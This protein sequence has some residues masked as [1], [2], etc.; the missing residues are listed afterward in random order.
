[1]LRGDQKDL[2]ITIAPKHTGQ[3]RQVYLNC[4][5]AFGDFSHVEADCWD[6]VLTELARLKEEA[7][8]K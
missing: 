4:D 6:H 1:M 5:V 8:G 2:R 3:Y 7:K